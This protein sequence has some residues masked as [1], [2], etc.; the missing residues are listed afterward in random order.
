[1]LTVISKQLG[2][3]WAHPA[4]S[5]D[6]WPCRPIT[7][8]SEGGLP[9]PQGDRVGRAWVSYAAVLVEM[10]TSA[11]RLRSLGWTESP[12]G[13]GEA[14]LHSSPPNLQHQKNTE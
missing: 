1:M 2:S 5:G 4:R 14:R 12:M 13:A 8:G 3:S 6:T 10:V 11:G 7:E 9:P